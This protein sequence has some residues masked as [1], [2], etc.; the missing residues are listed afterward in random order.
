[1]T[2]H[3]LNASNLQLTNWQGQEINDATQVFDPGLDENDDY[4]VDYPS[5]EL[6]RVD[7]PVGDVYENSFV[8][9]P[10]DEIPGVDAE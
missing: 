8:K 1:M 9:C 4:F 10:T 5:G 2:D 3:C 7:V 6:P